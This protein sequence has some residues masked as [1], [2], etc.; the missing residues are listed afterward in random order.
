MMFAPEPE[1]ERAA[2]LL[3]ELHRDGAVRI[4]V[5]RGVWQPEIQFE[6]TRDVPEAEILTTDEGLR[7]ALSDVASVL[8][9]AGRGVSREDFAAFRS[10]PRRWTEDEDE[11]LDE[12]EDSAPVEPSDVA[13]K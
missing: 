12:D 4:L 8:A 7:D 6:V 1:F 9:A 5:N 2:K 3:G 11:E 10:D 13:E